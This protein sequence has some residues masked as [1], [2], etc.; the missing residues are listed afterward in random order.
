MMRRY[1]SKFINWHLGLRNLS[2]SMVGCEAE[3][4]YASRN[5]KCQGFFSGH[6]NGSM[7]KAYATYCAKLPEDPQSTNLA[8]D[9][10]IDSFGRMHTYL[11]I[12]L[13]ERCNLRCQYCMPA[14]GV[15]L[16]RSP[17]L[18]SQDEIVHLANLFVSSGV[19][20]IRLTGGEPTIRKDIEDICLQLSNLKGLKTL[21]M[22]TNGITLARKLPKLKECG[23]TSLNISLDTLV[24]AKFEFLTR[25]KGHERVMDS[26]NAAIDC[27]YNPVKVNCVVMRG[28]NDDEICDFVELTHNKPINVRFIEFMPFDGN[29]WNVKKLVPYSEMLDRVGKQ[30]PS[31]KRLQDHPADTAKNFR[32]DG[33]LGMVSFITSMTEH[34]CA[35]C[36]RLRLLADG[37]FKVCLFGPSEVSLRDP[38]REGAEEHELREII[39]AAVKRKKASHAGMFDI[40][41]TANRPMIHIGG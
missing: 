9:M 3:S 27:G 41:K 12:S 33:H 4:Y 26:I 24:P 6:L 22:T 19:D 23:L 31:L 16:T 17:Q 38:L 11:R 28:F 13:T 36:N 15:E 21:A 34:F 8:S 1:T 37:N 35:G 32:I 5:S 39:G 29:V 2:F 40:A 14:E 7:P 18:L 20:K 30:F 25:R 10:L